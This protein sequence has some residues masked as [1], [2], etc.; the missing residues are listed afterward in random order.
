MPCD[1]AQIEQ[2]LQR[3]PHAPKRCF[4]THGEDGPADCLRQRIERN[5]GWNVT[6]PL[7]LDKVA[8]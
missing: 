8:L 1:T 6:V 7:Y 4:V 5:L 3:I 2:W